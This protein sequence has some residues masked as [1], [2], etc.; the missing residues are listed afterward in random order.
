M[1][2][3]STSATRARLGNGL[4]LGLAALVLAGGRQRG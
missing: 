4:E 3:V 1:I 2:D